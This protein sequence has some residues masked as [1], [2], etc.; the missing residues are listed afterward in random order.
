[1]SFLI[2][3]LVP[4]EGIELVFFQLWSRYWSKR[5][6]F[7]L[8]LQTFFSEVSLLLVGKKLD[9]FNASRSFL[10]GLLQASQVDESWNLAKWWWAGQL[11]CVKQWFI[12][13]RINWGCKLA[14]ALA[15]IDFLTS[16]S[17]LLCSYPHCSI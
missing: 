3:L 14:F 1:M 13:Y 4:I 12:S 7:F 15:L 6:C 5:R 9:S 16:S 2:L 17:Q 11:S 8:S 10:T